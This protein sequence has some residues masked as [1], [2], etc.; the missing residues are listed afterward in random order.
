MANLILIGRIS[1]YT[2]LDQ[3]GHLGYMYTICT[4]WSLWSNIRRFL[5]LSFLEC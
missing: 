3:S 1:K 5:I 4:Q 2:R